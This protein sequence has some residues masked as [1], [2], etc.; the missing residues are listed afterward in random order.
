MAFSPWSLQRWVYRCNHRSVAK[1]KP[2]NRRACAVLRQRPSQ[3]HHCG[4]RD[5]SRNNGPYNTKQKHKWIIRPWPL[6]DRNLRNLTR[7]S[8]ITP[9]AHF[10]FGVGSD[11]VGH[12]GVR[13]RCMCVCVSECLS[14][15]SQIISQTQQNHSLWM[16][17]CH[18]MRSIDQ[19]MDSELATA[20]PKWGVATRVGPDTRP[21]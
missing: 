13:A 20:D 14:C 2:S 8:I 6:Y 4:M 9:K 21:L 11:V 15:L 16:K 17:S 18:E 1:T 3:T 19:G 7:R 5:M 12:R 10:Q